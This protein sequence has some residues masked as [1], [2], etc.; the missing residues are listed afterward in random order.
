MFIGHSG[1]Q[2][3][4]EG[5]VSVEFRCSNVVAV[6]NTARFIYAKRLLYTFGSKQIRIRFFM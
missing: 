5:S 4:F 6:I 2:F 1:H 3:D